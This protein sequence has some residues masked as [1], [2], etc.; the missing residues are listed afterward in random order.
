[1]VSVNIWY[2]LSNYAACPNKEKNLLFVSQL[3][4]KWI[5][6]MQLCR[7]CWFHCSHKLHNPGLNLTFKKQSHNDNYQHWMSTVTIYPFSCTGNNYCWRSHACRPL[8]VPRCLWLSLTASRPVSQ[9][10][11]PWLGECDSSDLKPPRGGITWD[12]PLKM[13]IDMTEA[14]CGSHLGS[15]P[16]CARLC[17][18]HMSKRSSCMCQ[19]N[20]DLCWGAYSRQRNEA[21]TVR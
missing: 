18:L 4:K 3:Q 6:T 1:M 2:R 9:R 21:A 19:N 8:L 14:S 5:N 11:Y 17:T 16:P 10:L 15:T 7:S 20:S 13:A 12:W